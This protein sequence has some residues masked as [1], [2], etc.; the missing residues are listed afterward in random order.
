MA[1]WSLWWRGEWLFEFG[2]QKAQPENRLLTRTC[3]EAEANEVV[4]AIKEVPATIS[5]PED[6]RKEVVP[7]TTANTTV[8]T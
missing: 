3:G 6:V 7:R 4:P 1:S 5:A 2:P 8:I